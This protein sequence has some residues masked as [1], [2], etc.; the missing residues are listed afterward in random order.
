LVCIK[1]NIQRHL[2]VGLLMYEIL[3]IY[4]SFRRSQG[5]FNNRPYRIPKDFN[6]F[7]FETM[8]EKNREYLTY[9]TKN[10][11]TKWRHIDPN[12]FFDCG[13]E[14]F[15]KNFSYVR[16]FDRKVLNLYI[17]RDK[18]LKRA[19]KISRAAIIDDIKFIK[20]YLGKGM[21]EQVKGS[22]LI[23]YCCLEENGQL[24]PI[25]HY[26]LNGISRYIIVWMIDRGYLRL[27][28]GDRELL[29]L[30]L[31]NY[32]EYLDEVKSMDNFVGDLAHSHGLLR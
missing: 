5:G 27:K 7:L 12:R 19:Q 14:A 8:S 24:I 10:F 26:L 23:N 32:R 9:A 2:V 20:R 30:I 18:N 22:P 17:E 6:K 4:T 15:G 13:F 31:E 29:P 3:D 16:F 21:I 25:R 11:N 1:D 28:D